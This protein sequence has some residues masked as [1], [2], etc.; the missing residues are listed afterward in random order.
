VTTD[1]AELLD[2][3]QPSA[4][5]RRLESGE[6]S[7][8][9]PLPSVATLAEHYGV[10]RATVAR[11]LRTLATEDL[12][13]IVRGRSRIVHRLIPAA[14]AIRFL[15][16][17][18]QV[19]ELASLVHGLKIAVCRRCRQIAHSGSTAVG[20]TGKVPGRAR[21][22]GGTSGQ[23]SSWLAGGPARR[24]PSSADVF[25][26]LRGSMLRIRL[27]SFLHSML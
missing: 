8:G 20:F 11:S 1:G 5:R 18:S 14:H 7:S 23:A 16:T 26:P 15:A 4:L 12:V 6:C 21:Q 9:D 25:L 22:P 24:H 17:N 10:A 3:T 2:E 27:R 13:R 19:P